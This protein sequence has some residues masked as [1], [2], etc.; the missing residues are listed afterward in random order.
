M[1]WNNHSKDV[2]EGDH[3][4][5]GA[6]K[7]SWVNDSE[8]EFVDR[9]I[10]SYATETG[11]LLHAFCKLMIDHRIKFLKSDNHAVMV[12]LLDHKLPRFAINLANYISTISL[13]INDA[14]GF[15]LNS[16]QVLY[17][18]RN[19]FG[20]ADAISFKNNKL[21]I[22]DLKTGTSKVSFIQ[23]EIYAALFC[24]EYN[25]DPKDIEI[26]LRIYQNGEATSYIP[27]ADSIKQLM[28]KIKRFDEI[29][30]ELNEE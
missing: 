25:A 3:A 5:L 26:E 9:Y 23:L 11:T 19:S 29:I 30:N 2:R 10:K 22:H 28:S 17:Y 4:I 16:E 14:I 15:G 20:T 21:R 1:L 24:L 7:H 18:S 13:F 8:E 12:Y 6:S 27:E